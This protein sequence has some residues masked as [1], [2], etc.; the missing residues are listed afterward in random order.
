MYDGAQLADAITA[1]PDDVEAALDVYEEALLR[2]SADA[3][4][5]GR[6]RLRGLLRRHHPH[7]L[8]EL[9]TGNVS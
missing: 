4:R 8:V 7:S 5:R 3:T 6:S 1:H 9:F 2:R